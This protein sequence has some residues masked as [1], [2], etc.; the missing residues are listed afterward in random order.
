MSRPSAAR[1]YLPWLAWVALGEF[2]GFLVPLAAEALSLAL[3]LPDLLAAALLAVAGAG[4]GA[5]LGS[6]QGW[7]LSREAPRLKRRRFA[8]LTAAAAAVAWLLGM[9]PVVA[10]PVW[11]RWPPAL[12]AAAG[13][14]VAALLLAS[15]GTGQ[16][17]ALRRVLPGAWM[18]IPST[19][20]AS[21]VGL[22]AFFAVATPL[23]Q[24]GQPFALVL[25][26]GAL[27]AAVMALGMAAVTGWAAGRLLR[28]SAAA[29]RPV[30]SAH[31]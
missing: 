16:W 9:L 20:A 15:I 25:A 27:A 21:C 28:R 8:A 14:A 29:R 10:E 24:E 26:I 2:A 1:F 17:L 12:A 4:E 18:W 13:I 5:I 23:W 31:E 3:G 30:S 6:V 22:G 7:R 11:T 19:A